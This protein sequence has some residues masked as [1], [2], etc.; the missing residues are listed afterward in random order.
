M[1]PSSHLDLPT[2]CRKN[3]QGCPGDISRTR[4]SDQDLSRQSLES[5][6]GGPAEVGVSTL[7]PLGWTAGGVQKL[8]DLGSRDGWKG[9]SQHRAGDIRLSF[10]PC[11]VFKIPPPGTGLAVRPRPARASLGPWRHSESL[12]SRCQTPHGAT[13]LG[14]A[15]WARCPGWDLPRMMPQGRAGGAGPLGHWASH[16][17]AAAA[18]PSTR[19]VLRRIWD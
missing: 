3:P 7:G 6:R 2:S 8:R 18:E 10:A 4:P 1:R 17:L 19:S 9:A 5:G 11:S 13:A 14:R 16:T 12:S 15:L